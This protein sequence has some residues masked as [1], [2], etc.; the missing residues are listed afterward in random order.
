M[1]VV[2]PDGRS[3]ADDG[4]KKEEHRR[5]FQ[6]EHMQHTSDRAGSNPAC[7]VKGA[8]PTVL[9]ALSSRDT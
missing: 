6:P 9:A 8:Y 7:V 3:A 2:L 4:E 1:P 5:D